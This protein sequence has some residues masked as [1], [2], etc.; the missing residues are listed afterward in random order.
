MDSTSHCIQ[1]RLFG[2]PTRWDRGEPKLSIG[3]SVAIQVPEETVNVVPDHHVVPNFV[4]GWAF[5]DAIGVGL[6][7]LNGWWTVTEVSLREESLKV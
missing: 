4:D 6:L 1:I 3:F 2:D 7:S 5:G